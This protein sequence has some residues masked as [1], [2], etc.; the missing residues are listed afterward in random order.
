MSTLRLIHRP[1]VWTRDRDYVLECHCAINY[2]CDCPWACERPYAAYRAE[3][4]SLRGQVEGFSDA[5]L[6]SARDARAIAEIIEDQ[7]GA[8]VGYLWAPFCED[9]ESGFTF[10]DVQ[11][12]YIEKVY[13]RRG[14]AAQL[15]H[16]A[17]ERA[18]QA[19]AKVIRS[20]TGCG[21]AASI[22]LHEKNGFYPY[23]VELEKV[24]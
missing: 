16:Y 15:L 5:I 19:G 11:D 4:F 18:R 12:L 20:G 22:A 10:M 3:W 17:Q 23:R 7:D 2:A 24:L 6:R 21:N 8:R 13:R 1:I 14:V 9:A